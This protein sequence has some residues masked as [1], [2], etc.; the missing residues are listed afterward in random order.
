M[1]IFDIEAQKKKY[2]DE[3]PEDK[4]KRNKQQMFPAC[5]NLAVGIAMVAVGAHFADDDNDGNATEFLKVGGSVLIVSNALKILSYLTKCECDDKIADFITPLLDFAYFIVVIWGSVKVFG[6]YSDI[7]W[8]AGEEEADT[9][10]PKHAFMFAFVYLI[11][12]WVFLPLACCCGA[13]ACC[14]KVCAKI[15]PPKGEG[16]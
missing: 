13:M 15:S 2:S 14:C 5:I 10:C 1:E 6:A 8:D 16:E 12:Y 11:C 4:Q 3:T 9:Y 7:L